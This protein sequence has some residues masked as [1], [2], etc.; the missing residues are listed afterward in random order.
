MGGTGGITFRHEEVARGRHLVTV[1]AS[2]GIGETESSIAQRILISANRFAGA[3]C[4][5]GF[6]FVDDP[7][8]D[9]KTAGGFMRRS[10]TYIFLCS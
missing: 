1:T 3:Q 4:P 2:P 5:G 7:N 6:T 10:R 8:A 9:Q